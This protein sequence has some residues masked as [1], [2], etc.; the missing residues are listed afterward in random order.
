MKFRAVWINPETKETKT[1]EFDE[2]TWT[3]AMV[4]TLSNCGN[5]MYLLVSL[6]RID[7]GLHIPVYKDPPDEVDQLAALYIKNSA[8]A[9]RNSFGNCTS[10]D[11]PSHHH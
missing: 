10:C 11:D 6:T 9:N 8:E 4:A 5:P 7:L 1:D 2:F 3:H